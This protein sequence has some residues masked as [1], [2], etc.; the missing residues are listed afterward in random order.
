[1][2]DISKITLP[3]G[4][5]YNLKD[6][7]ARDDIAA[8][9]SAIAGGVTFMGETTTA[10][11]DGATTNPITIN[12]KS[13]TA[14]KGY[15]VVYN[16]KEFVFD[17]TKWIEMGDLSILGALAYKDSASGSYQPAG[18]NTAPTFHGTS[19]AVTITATANTNGN[20]QPAGSITK[21]TFTGLNTT[22][23]GSFKPAGDVTFTNSNK[24]ATV[25]AAASGTKTYTPDGTIDAPTISVQNAGSTTSITPFGGLGSLPSWAAKVTGETLSFEFSAGVL[26]T[27]GTA[28][29]VKT[30][31]ATYSAS[32]PVFHGADVRLVTDNISVP[33]SASFD[34]TSGTV[35]VSG[36]PNGEVAAPSFEGTKVQL[37][38]ATTASGTVDAPAFT[39][40]PTT[41]TVT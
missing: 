17:G 12:N 27:P 9:E 30:G 1:M 14:I 13:V 33:I 2:A 3:T 28:V 37:S 18:T 5:T 40:T 29:T 36:K 15:L 25:S 8:I 7:Q 23:T 24:T 19:S 4:N 31:D 41:I 11:T 22:M 26:P 6:Q 35:S 21:P 38:G 10:L 16:N 39:G 32:A 20:Y 34:G